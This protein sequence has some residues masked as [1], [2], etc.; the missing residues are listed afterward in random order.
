VTRPADDERV[1]RGLTSQLESW[2]A[3][4]AG[5]E[6]RLGWKI[7][8]NLPA[9]QEQLGITGP[10][11]GNLTSANE[12]PSGGEYSLA[13]GTAVVVEPEIAL[14]VGEGGTIAALAP[15]IE[16]V[17][18]DLPIEDIELILARNVFHRAVVLGQP[19]PG[20]A[21]GNLDGLTVSV[22]RNGAEE[23]SADVASALGDPAAVVSV[24]AELLDVAGEELRAGDVIIS[25]V[26]TPLVWPQEGDLIEADFGPLG[27]LAV[28]F[29]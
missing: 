28:S 21:G 11:I 25:G 14:H 22:A 8:F 26:L 17:D 4:L 19:D 29:T 23:Q 5:G 3:R 24:V 2:R 12:L 10:V 18:L 20:R 16:I 7:G 13:G 1:V 27:R 6:R 15:A 9:M